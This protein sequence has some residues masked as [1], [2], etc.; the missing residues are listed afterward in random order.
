MKTELPNLRRNETADHFCGLWLSK[1]CVH[2]VRV[3]GIVESINQ[4]KGSAWVVRQSGAWRTRGPS[5]DVYSSTLATA[6]QM[7]LLI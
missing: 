7:I 5:A 4:V 3:C 2:F 1:F 6:T